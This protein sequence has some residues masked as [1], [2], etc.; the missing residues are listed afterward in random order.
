MHDPAFRDAI[1][2]GVRVDPARA[3]GEP[4]VVDVR[5][6]ERL[7]ALDDRPPESIDLS[8]PWAWANI[9]GP[10][11]EKVVRIE[12]ILKTNFAYTHQHVMEWAARLAFAVK[13]GVGGFHAVRS[14]FKALALMQ[15][16]GTVHYR[17]ATAW[18]D[19]GAADAYR[20]ELVSVYALNFPCPIELQV[21]DRWDLF[22][23]DRHEFFAG[24]VDAQVTRLE[25]QIDEAVTAAGPFQNDLVGLLGGVV[26]QPGLAAAMLLRSLD[27]VGA[28]PQTQYHLL[29][30]FEPG[31][32]LAASDDVI[33][34]AINASEWAH[35][36]PVRRNW[37]IIAN[38]VASQLA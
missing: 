27:P 16:N 25:W 33:D 9:D 20:N 17:I 29:A 7:R 13:D 38:H 11:T 10:N 14:H 26:A 22:Y 36:G 32:A 6:L 12:G 15:E 21:V 28:P 8:R 1:Q 37:T 2:R 30:G 19:G 24:W 31:T 3:D 34:G 5:T 35:A 18:T 23:A 4:N